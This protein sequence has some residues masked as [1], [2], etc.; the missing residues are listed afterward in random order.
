MEKII[1]DIKIPNLGEAEST[2]II[3]ISTK[4]GARIKKNEPLLVLESEK[5]AMEV[6][7]DFNGIINEFCV[8]EGETVKE[9]MVFARIEVDQEDSET[10]KKQEKKLE[11][12]E[13]QEKNDIKEKYKPKAINFNHS[14][15]INAGPAVRKYARELEIDLN[16]IKP[17]SPSGRITKE[18]LKIFIHSNNNIN[19][20]PDIEKLKNYGEYEIK[21]QSKQRV[22][23]AQ[24]LLNSWRNIPHVCHFE[25]ADISTLESQRRELNKVSSIKISPLAFFV[26]ATCIAL[27]NNILFNSS[28]INDGEL[29]VKKYIN[30][31]IAVSTEE[32]LIV[33]V[34][35]DADKMN[36]GQIAGSIN[37]ISEKAR[38]KKL[39]N[40]DLEGATFTISSLGKI[41]GTGFT[42]II[43]PPEVGIIG[44]SNVKSFLEFDGKSHIQKIVLP[45]SLSYDHRVINGADAGKFMQEIKEIL[46]RGINI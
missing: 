7:S 42:P 15:N 5:A 6:P 43:N 16:L 31:G 4:K 19:N 46:E 44:I 40:K 20:Y 37:Q 11:I 24:N 38:N 22:L 36:I 17:T 39:L 2:E 23:A 29:L 10:S 13:N 30:I 41:G 14:R 25:E 26:K 12:L 1:L 3:E 9:G 21:K 18:D 27:E 32:G 33:P 45:F 35:K 34:L 28:L 8:K